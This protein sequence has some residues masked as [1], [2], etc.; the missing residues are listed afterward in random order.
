MKDIIGPATVLVPKTVVGLVAW[1]LYG[2][3]TGIAFFY[4]AFYVTAILL[5]ASARLR[6][7]VPAGKVDGGISGAP[8]RRV[9]KPGC[10]GQPHPERGHV[11]INGGAG[12]EIGR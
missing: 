9:E 5:Y 3:F 10:V 7:E 6:S 4:G 2:G 1:R 11:G 12:I 8:R